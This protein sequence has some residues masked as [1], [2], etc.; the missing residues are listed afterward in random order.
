MALLYFTGG[1]CAPNQEFATVLGAQFTR[2]GGLP[3]DVLGAGGDNRGSGSWHMTMT[4]ANGFD[5]RARRKFPVDGS[6]QDFYVKF[7]FTFSAEPQDDNAFLFTLYDVAGTTWTLFRRIYLDFNTG[8]ER[9]LTI[10]GL[11]SD[12]ARTTTQWTIN[13]NYL[14]TWHIHNESGNTYDELKVY[15]DDGTLL[16]TL[17]PGAWTYG[18]YTT[19]SIQFG[20]NMAKGGANP[21]TAIKIDHLVICDGSGDEF[22]VMPPLTT[23]V[24]ATLPD[25]D[26]TQEWKLADGSTTSTY[27]VV[28]ELLANDATDYVRS[29]TTD[30]ELDMLCE[31][32]GQSELWDSDANPLDPSDYTLMAG[33]RIDGLQAAFRYRQGTASNAS[34]MQ[35]LWNDNGTEGAEA[36]SYNATEGWTCH[37]GG[38]DVI[39]A[40]FMTVTPSGGYPW[41]QSILDTFKIGLRK[42]SGATDFWCTCINVQ[43][44]ISLGAGDYQV[45]A[46]GPTETAV[47]RVGAATFMG[48][49]VGVA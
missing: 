47:D 27:T 20:Q 35:F 45:P 32:Q 25:G 30:A 15:D 17:S 18:A 33:D 29:M 9:K 7:A 5:A 28:D 31:I 26:S 11:S 2:T 14:V 48:L 42:V 3:L 13:T 37:R 16:E 8:H 1:E 38:A 34:T 36:F 46:Q 10:V 4:N 44:C 12:Y 43:A 40:K 22:N 21:N 19:D 41:P 49:S 23:I 39:L 6:G 24:V